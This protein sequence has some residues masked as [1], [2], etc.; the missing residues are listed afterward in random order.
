MSDVPDQR[1][2]PQPRVLLLCSDEPQHRYLA[3]VLS[4]SVD[5]VGVVIEPGSAQRRAVWRRRRYRDWLARVYHEWR[6]AVTGRT[7]Y[8]RRYFDSLCPDVTHV[9]PVVVDSVNSSATTELVAKVRPDLAVVCCTSVIE[10]GVIDQAPLMINVHGGCL[11]HYRG[12]HCIYFAYRARDYDHVAAT[13]HIVTPQ[14]D[15]GDIIETIRPAIHPHDHDGHLY[16]R[17]VHVGMLR[18]AELL[19][20]YRVGD[21][22]SARPQAEVGRMYRNKDRTPPMDVSLWLRRRLGRHAVPHTPVDS[23][24]RGHENGS[25][26]DED[27]RVAAPTASG[28]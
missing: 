18:L 10:P 19:S 8:R 15:A 17:A 14:L 20:E 1:E 16:C 25:R 26:P 21:E 24:A 5:L 3:R 22:I 7:R 4:S 27:S 6:Q 9:A 12:N 23:A 2:N 11:P 28:A 13:L